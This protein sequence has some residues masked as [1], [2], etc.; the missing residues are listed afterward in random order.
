[1]PIP[2]GFKIFITPVAIQCNGRDV[3]NTIS[4]L[5]VLLTENC[6]LSLHVHTSTKL[7]F[8]DAI[9]LHSL[10]AF[11]TTAQK[12]TYSTFAE[13]MLT[14][15]LVVKLV[16]VGSR[17][18]KAIGEINAVTN[19]GGAFIGKVCIAIS[20]CITKCSFCHNTHL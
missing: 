1:M 7:F 19:A 3:E 15:I 12:Y 14:L 11:L 5:L 10:Q 18:Q 6:K 2:I 9:L 17:R 13:L 16:Q 8:A 4:Y 20:K